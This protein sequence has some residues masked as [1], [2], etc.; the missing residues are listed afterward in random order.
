MRE[1]KFRAWDKRLKIMFEVSEINLGHNNYVKGLGGQFSRDDNY[2]LMQFTGL[3]DKTGKEIY[4]EDILIYYK[5]V[6][7]EILKI[8]TKVKFCKYPDG[9][10]YY[11]IS[12][13]GYIAEKDENHHETLIDINEI[14]EIIGNIQSNP[15]L[16][17]NK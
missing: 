15:E 12:H 9:E 14:S 1:I 11:D 3:H 16:L 7:S 10:Q 13:Y 2:I 17:E 4:E 5:K 6:K 8:T